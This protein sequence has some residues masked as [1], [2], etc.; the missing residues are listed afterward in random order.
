MNRKEAVK[1]II[2]KHNSLA[3]QYAELSN[4]H[5]LLAKDYEAYQY[6]LNK[7]GFKTKGWKRFTGKGRIEPYVIQTENGQIKDDSIFTR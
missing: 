3:Q 7:P 4:Y 6:E 5:H 1:L 2:S